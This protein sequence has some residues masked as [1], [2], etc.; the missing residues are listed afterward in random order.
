MSAP[1]N[2]PSHT[3]S[4]AEKQLDARGYEKVGKPVEVATI[5]PRTNG[6]QGGTIQWHINPK[7]LGE[8]AWYVLDKE[9]HQT[10]DQG[11]DAFDQAGNANSRDN[12]LSR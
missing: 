4:F 1:K 11:P 6:K 2:Y 5:W 3:I 7:H 12:G 10:Q 9:R 8:G